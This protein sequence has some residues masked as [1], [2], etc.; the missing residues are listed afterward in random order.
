MVKNFFKILFIN[1]IIA[2]VIFIFLNLVASLYLRINQKAEI[3]EGSE[4]FYSGR[5]ATKILKMLYPGESIMGCS[6]CPDPVPHTVVDFISATSST[7]T[8]SYKVGIEGIRYQDNWDD[9]YVKKSLS[10]FPIFVIGGSTTFGAFVKNEHTIP[11]YLNYLDTNNT[12]LNFGTS[13]YDSIREINRL[14]YLLKKGHRPKK[15]IFVVG[16]NDISNFGRSPYNIHDTPN[17]WGF[18]NRSPSDVQIIFGHQRGNSMRAILFSLPIIKLIK[19]IQFYQ[20]NLGDVYEQH[21]GDFVEP[22]LLKKLFDYYY[23]WPSIRVNWRENLSRDIMRYYKQSIT[24]TEALGRGFGFS[25]HFIY[26]PIGLTEKNN[27][28]IKV[29]FENS[30]LYKIYNHVDLKLKSA[31]SNGKLGMKDCSGSFANKTSNDYWMDP[32][33]YSPRGNLL[34]AKCI[35]NVIDRKN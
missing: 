29:G 9:E 33:H 4:Y 17:L 16:G 23:Y 28:F 32:T 30:N 1:L 31:I 24:F 18:F 21:S 2:T 11:R 8:S 34:L 19:H 26:P 27:P 15:V 5:D 25:V 3:F 35:L 12:Y 14:I 22:M 20:N 10:S 13:G 6:S 7:P